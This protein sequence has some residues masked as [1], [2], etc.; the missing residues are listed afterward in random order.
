MRM[1]Q[2]ESFSPTEHSTEQEE[3]KNPWADLPVAASGGTTEG[4]TR[5]PRSGW[6]A[7]GE[8]LRRS[9]GEAE[10]MRFKGDR[11]LSR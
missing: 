8:V 3:G 11:E 4:G 2:S 7:P 5:H 1:N 6:S 9:R 10:R